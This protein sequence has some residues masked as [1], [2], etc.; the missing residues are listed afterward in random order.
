M[1]LEISLQGDVT[2]LTVSGEFNVDSVARFNEAV[3][4][5]LASQRRDFV[6]DLEKVTAIDSAGLEALTA[7]QRQC[8]DQLGIARLCGVDATIRKILE[9]TRLDKLFT[10][11]D[12]AEDALASFAQA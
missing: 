11:C 12:S 3:A 1:K 9:I 6:V 5:A 7:M 2:V 10:L 4:D 8:E